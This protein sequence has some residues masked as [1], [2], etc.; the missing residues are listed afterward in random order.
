MSTAPSVRS[1]WFS[2]R[3][4]WLAIAL[5]AVAAAVLAAC[6]SGVSADSPADTAA[7]N[8]ELVRRLY[9]ANGDPSAFRELTAPDLVWD[10]TPGFPDGGVYHGADGVF[11][12]FGKLM[13]RVDAWP[14][15]VDG[16]F[17]SGTDTVFVVG[18]YQPSKHGVSESVR[19][20]HEWT[21]RDGKLTRMY[22]AADSSVAQ[23]LVNS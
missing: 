10:V 1:S 23:R 2:A 11:E 4:R 15:V 20:I 5:T 6:S 8:T 18:H 17:P 13:P 9:Q 22:Q 21:V 12:Y 19:F 3:R 7:S 16:Y 14:T